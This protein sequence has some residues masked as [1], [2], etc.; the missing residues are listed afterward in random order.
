MS[1]LGTGLPED[2]VLV[3]ERSDYYS[4]QAAREMTTSGKI[5]A[6]VADSRC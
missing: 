6:S 2:L 5:Q 4:L 1:D 3:H